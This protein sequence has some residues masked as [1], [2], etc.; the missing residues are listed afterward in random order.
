MCDDPSLTLSLS[1]S[2]FSSRRRICRYQT[3]QYLNGIAF[4]N[5]IARAN[6]P[7]RA[8]TGGSRSPRARER[9]REKREPGGRTSERERE[10]EREGGGGEAGLDMVRITEADGANQDAMRLP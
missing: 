5:V 8:G 1:L 9:E 4:G 6:T 2:L 7:D 3:R 10:R